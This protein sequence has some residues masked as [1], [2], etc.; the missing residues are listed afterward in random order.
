M[1]LRLRGDRVRLR[2]DRADLD[3]LAA[4]G[5]ITAELLTRGHSAARWSYGVHLDPAVETLAVRLDAAGFRVLLPVGSGGD[6]LAS[7]DEGFYGED[8]GLHISLERDYRCLHRDAAG[9]EESQAV[10]RPEPSPR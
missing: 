2:L 8:G 10:D 1:K 3:R 7:E 4:E 6:W 5:R 9:P